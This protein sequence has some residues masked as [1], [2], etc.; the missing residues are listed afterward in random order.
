MLLL[1]ALWY[2]A[3]LTPLQE[4]QAG[5]HADCT[6]VLESDAVDEREF[7]KKTKSRKF[8]VRPLPNEH[9]LSPVEPY[10]AP[11]D[12]LNIASKTG[13]AIAH[14]AT[15]LATQLDPFG[16]S[17]SGEAAAAAAAEAAAAKAKACGGGGAHVLPLQVMVLEGACDANVPFLVRAACA[18]AMCLEVSSSLIKFMC[19]YH[20]CCLLI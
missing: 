11:P 20:F 15:S 9:Q 1:F 12:L 2:H 16:A 19:N 18:D 10:E 13:E 7:R 8:K 4:A 6:N 17:T 3:G 5:G 14:A